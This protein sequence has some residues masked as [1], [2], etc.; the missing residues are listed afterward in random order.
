MLVWTHLCRIYRSSMTQYHD[1]S[2]VKSSS[3]VYGEDKHCRVVPSAS[4]M[5]ELTPAGNPV[6][7]FP[8]EIWFPVGL[9]VS[10][11]DVVEIKE[12]RVRS[13]AREAISA[14]LSADAVEDATTIY[15][16]DPLGFAGAQEITI[17]DGT[18][19][20]RVVIKEVDDTEITLF[21][22]LDYDFDTGSDL[23][24]DSFYK[25]QTVKVPGAIG[26]VIQVT[27]IETF[28]AEYD[29]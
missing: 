11:G 8:V 27:A 17:S 3:D 2:R 1:L 13:G 9:A 16:D 22:P 19:A 18:N 12:T 10:P 29:D 23:E 26:P 5:F 24:V 14:E 20:Q 4:E 7:T 21:T 15:V 6:S 28:N 25:I